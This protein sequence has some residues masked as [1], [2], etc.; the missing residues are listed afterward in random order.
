MKPKGHH[1]V[2]EAAGLELFK[3]AFGSKHRALGAFYLGN[4]IADFSQ[5]V[6]PVGMESARELANVLSPISTI[7]EGIF[8][9]LHSSAALAERDAMNP[10]ERA[11]HEVPLA[12]LRLADKLIGVG[13]IIGHSLDLLLIGEDDTRDFAIAHMVHEL[14][15]VLGYFDF[16]FE[17]EDTQEKDEFL[18]TFEEYKAVFGA[19]R[20]SVGTRPAPD[21]GSQSQPA[22]P[23]PGAFTQY[24]PHEHYDRPVHP[25]QDN[26]VAPGRQE[27]SGK[28]RVG[29]TPGEQARDGYRSKKLPAGPRA[30]SS[31][32]HVARGEG[33]LRPL[34]PG[35][36]ETGPPDI[37]SYL[38]DYFE[39][40]AGLLSE[41]DEAFAKALKSPP[42][43][44]GGGGSY[45]DEWVQ[46]LA[47]AGHTIHQIEDFFAHSNFVELAIDQ[48]KMK[49]HFIDTKEGLFD[50]D[51]A[52]TVFDLRLR[53][54]IN[55]P[56]KKPEPWFVD[57]AE[58]LGA[59]NPFGDGTDREIFDARVKEPE[60]WVVTAY[61]DIRD[62]ILAIMHSLHLGP[63][64]PHTKRHQNPEDLD[65]LDRAA[66][67]VVD[68]FSSSGQEVQATMIDLYNLLKDP[69][70]ALQAAEN[71]VV[72]EL[73]EKQPEMVKQKE[74]AEQPFFTEQDI[75]RIS[76]SLSLMKGVHPE[77]LQRFTNFFVLGNKVRA[78]KGLVKSIFEAAGIVEKAI[79]NPVSL[80]SGTF[81]DIASE[82]VNHMV[83]RRIFK[84]IGAERI[85]CHSLIA[86]DH[87][88][89]TL[90]QPSFHCAAAVHAHIFDVL[91]RDRSADPQDQYVDWLE[92][93][94]TLLRN[95]GTPID[96]RAATTVRI[97]SH[98]QITHVVTR[99]E[100]LDTLSEPSKSLT[101]RYSRTSMQKK[102]R[103]YNART[104]EDGF[105][106]RMIA[107]VNFAT[108]GQ[109]DATARRMINAA[110]KSIGAPKVGGVNYALK[111]GMKLQIPFQTD[112]RDIEIAAQD[113]EPWWEKVLR[114]DKPDWEVVRPKSMGGPG[115]GHELR[116]ISRADF[117]DTI[118]RGQFLREV[119]R[120][121]YRPEAGAGGTYL[122]PNRTDHKWP[123][124]T[125][126]L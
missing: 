27:E 74:S 123:F 126:H 99:G 94:E 56:K 106:W 114:A 83:R 121:F 122:A 20:G 47:K 78:T 51:F 52:S 69:R 67:H 111:P 11:L 79:L 81:T 61:F 45:A 115:I 68:P 28:L 58:L 54:Y 32:D 10:L 77:V 95:P 21:R 118:A 17:R 70:A 110:L 112:S 31:T 1:G 100:Q 91:L 88:E 113:T 6:E 96:D 37:Y 82:N 102:Y 105:H 16:A 29:P 75:S 120:E 76:E 43:P 90:Y 18:L 119:F 38:R 65:P 4:W 104:P 63:E 117:K 53:R 14:F 125:N 34:R 85:G 13:D 64:D 46:L 30:K 55:L 33:N 57:A 86:K 3:K 35:A 66:L 84:A 109:S 60:T 48:L 44:R 39:G 9:E 107:D 101:Q 41:L 73:K 26:I 36:K 93:L 124:A 8:E 87:E 116:Y 98:G 49:E 5:M 22:P 59:A 40:T 15:F 103:P 25:T 108:T 42:Q 19:R 72:R 89:G 24:Y 50:R 7:I 80:V 23:T 97:K 2:A 62:T 12:P 92:L 71:R